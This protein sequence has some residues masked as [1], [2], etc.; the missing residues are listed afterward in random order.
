MHG[1]GNRC[2][3]G[4]GVWHAPASW[5]TQ[6]CR[7]GG[8]AVL[9]RVW[10]PVLTVG[11]CRV[12]R[13]CARPQKARGRRRGDPRRRGLLLP[14]HG[15]QARPSAAAAVP[16]HACARGGR[17][18]RRCA[19]ALARVCDVV[20]ARAAAESAREVHA[21]HLV[22]GGAP[23]GR[24]E[25]PLVRGLAGVPRMHPGAPP[26]TASA[27]STFVFPPSQLYAPLCIRRG[28]LQAQAFLS[29]ITAAWSVRRS[30]G[31]TLLQIDHNLSN[32]VYAYSTLRRLASWGYHPARCVS[33]EQPG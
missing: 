33:R 2:R 19:A 7:W 24:R 15:P 5:H 11:R 8:L 9:L 26:P 28:W 22:P 27:S 14:R 3:T 20:R 1:S 18:G 32:A 4:P 29:N 23:G 31:F 17:R 30:R 12:G 21:V 16:A 25:Q 10:L 13:A 6:N